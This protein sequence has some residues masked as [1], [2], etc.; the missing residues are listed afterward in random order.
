MCNEGEQ[1]KAEEGREDLCFPYSSLN[2][3]VKTL[4]Y[5][6]FPEETPLVTVKPGSQATAAFGYFS[7]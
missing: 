1:H 4:C 5:F 6:G 3:N 7:N 2:E